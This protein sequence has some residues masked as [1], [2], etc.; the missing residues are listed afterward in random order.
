M[1]ESIGSRK[2]ARLA[3]FLKFFAPLRALRDSNIILTKTINA[4]FL[5]FTTKIRVFQRLSA[6]QKALIVLSN[7]LL[8]QLSLGYL[9]NAVKTEFDNL[10]IYPLIATSPHLRYTAA[11]ATILSTA[12]DENQN[13]PNTRV[14]DSH[15]CAS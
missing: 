10:Q 14:R 9:L 3:K 11:L 7:K 13:A 5:Q 6:S 2:G 8:E 15:L 12:I 1:V 4:D